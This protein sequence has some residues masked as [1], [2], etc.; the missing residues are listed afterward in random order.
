LTH[1][2]IIESL[3][4]NCMIDKDSRSRTF[5]ENVLALLEERFPWLGK[6]SDDQVSG[7]DTVDELSDLHRSLTDERTAERSKSQDTDQ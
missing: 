1:F 7:A 6:E 3:E 2:P 4:E 5:V